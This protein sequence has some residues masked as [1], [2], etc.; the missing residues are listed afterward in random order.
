MLDLLKSVGLFFLKLLGL[1]KGVVL[2]EKAI[3]DKISDNLNKM[4]EIDDK[5]YNADS[6]ADDI[7]K[8]K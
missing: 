3:D 6:L 1:Y 7:N 2:G 4:E 8:H 5:N